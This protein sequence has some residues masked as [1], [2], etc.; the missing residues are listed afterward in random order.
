MPKNY[1]VEV[2]VFAVQ[3]KKEGHT[4]ERVAEMVRQN[5]GLDPVP[6]RRQMTKWMA[7]TSVSDLVLARVGRDLPNY[8]TQMLTQQHDAMAKIVADVMSGKDFGIVIMKWMLSQ[9]KA[10]FGAQRLTAALAE[11]TQ[12]EARLEKDRNVANDK[13]GTSKGMVREDGER[14][15]E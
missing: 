4:W 1:P 3:K 2:R 5:F 7:K 9:M 12:E 6:S 8:A 13:I 14:S 10:N 11:L 15:Q